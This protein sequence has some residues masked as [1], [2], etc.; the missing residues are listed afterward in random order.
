M[1]YPL[2]AVLLMLRVLDT[3]KIFDTVFVLTGGGPGEATQVLSLYLYKTVFQFWELGRA[4]AGAV[5]IFLM[6][7]ILAG[8]L[9][10]L[11]SVRLKLF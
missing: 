9:Y 1:L 3:F 2:L 8:R 5:I 10:K 4:A 7:F 6:F 11:F